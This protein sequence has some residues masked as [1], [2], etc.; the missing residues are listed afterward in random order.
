[1][2]PTW[3][4]D[5]DQQI[6]HTINTTWSNTFFDHAMPLMRNRLIWAPLYIF[7][8]VYILMYYKRKAWIVLVGA[9]ITIGLSDNISSRLIKP[10]VKRPRPCHMAHRMMVQARVNCG[11]GYSFPSSHATNHFAFALFMS[12]L[13]GLKRKRNILW[14]TWAASI[15]FAQIYV[16][17]HY[18]VDVIMGSLL[19]AL[20][21]LRCVRWVLY[22]L[23][24]RNTEIV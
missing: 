17:V 9:A 21:G 23:N 10:F 18:P 11:P 1:M 2:S 8:L 15:G 19:G 7:A 16:G 14:L 4:I 5:L 12:G 6:F 13:M 3:L 20:I 24:R 22:F